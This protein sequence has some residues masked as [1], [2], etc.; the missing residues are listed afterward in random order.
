MKDRIPTKTIKVDNLGEE[1]TIELYQ[2]ATQDEEDELMNSLFGENGIEPGG[3]INLRSQN[4]TEYKKKL[5]TFFCKDLSW[6]EFNGMHP[7]AREKILEA[8][9]SPL[10][11]KK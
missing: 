2:W 5:V 1:K 7:D 10:K 9:D 11:K 3:T 4:I 8:I 6:E